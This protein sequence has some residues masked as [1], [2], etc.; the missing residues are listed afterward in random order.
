MRLP[1][2]G[3]LA[4]ILA[5]ACTGGPGQVPDQPAPAPQL[6]V[7]MQNMNDLALEWEFFDSL[8]DSISAGLI[9][10]TTASSCAKIP[11]P[12]NA[13]TARLFNGLED[14]A[15][16]PATR[17]YWTVKLAGTVALVED[18]KPPC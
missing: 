14:V 7:L 2:A 17:P 13:E 11:I 9:R 18:S 15:F 1:P 3:V 12:A 6:V 10:A 8:S 16:K 5:G 4:L